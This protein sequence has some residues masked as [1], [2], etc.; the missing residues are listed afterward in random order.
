MGR[1]PAAAL[2]DVEGAET[3][4]VLVVGDRVVL[5]VPQQVVERW[6]G[7]GHLAA[8]G[9]GMVTVASVEELRSAHVEA[10]RCADDLHARERR[11]RLE[12]VLRH[13]KP[14]THPDGHRWTVEGP[15]WR[16]C[17]LCSAPEP[18]DGDL[19]A[20]VDVL[21]ASIISRVAVRSWLEHPEIELEGQTPL[22]A[23]DAGDLDEVLR[24]ARKWAAKLSDG[25]G[26]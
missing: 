3:A 17:A 2:D 9:D 18:I 8:A 19:A 6:V 5:D 7:G 23:I 14:C 12:A 1:V 24:I 22:K 10:I 16:L 25:S 20:V 11:A 26:L 21:P 4:L 15:R 13:Y